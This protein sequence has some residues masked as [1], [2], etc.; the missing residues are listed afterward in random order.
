MEP[1][2]RCLDCGRSGFTG[3][4][5]HRCAD[6]SLNKNHNFEIMPKNETLIDADT[7]D[8]LP[9]EESSGQQTPTPTM[10]ATARLAAISPQDAEVAERI[11]RLYSDAVQ[12]LRKMVLCGAEMLEHKAKLKHG[13]FLPW[14]EKYCP[15]IPERTARRFM[16][17]A[18]SAI[19]LG[20]KVKALNQIG[21]D[22]RFDNLPISRLLQLPFSDLPPAAAAAQKQIFELVDG[23]TQ[24]QL[25]FDFRD[26][27]PPKRQYNP[28]VHTKA[29]VEQIKIDAA[30]DLVATLAQQLMLVDNQMI[31]RCSD[32][33]L[34]T[35]KNACLYVSGRIPNAGK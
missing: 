25:L 34:K 32:E 10:A 28:P 1:L 22:G 6:G 18:E 23:K 11:S 27:E 13:Q 35:L 8:N 16:D 21:H 3:P 9:Q 5:A 24:K 30:N 12:G 4:K 31:A 14:L 17:C 33:N 2:Y 20:L 26:T 29:Q 15:E 19:C 7:G